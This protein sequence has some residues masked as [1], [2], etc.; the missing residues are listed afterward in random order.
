MCAI[1]IT[2][3]PKY[4]KMLKNGKLRV[5]ASDT[6]N[7]YFFAGVSEVSS[8]EIRLQVKRGTT[9]YNYALSRYGGLEIIP[10]QMGNGKYIATLCERVTGN[11]YRKIGRVVFNVK[12]EDKL[13]PFRH[14]NLWIPYYPEIARNVVGQKVED[15]IRY[16]YAYDYVRAIRIKAGALP[17]ILTCYEK[18]MGICQDLA[19]M[20]VSLWRMFGIPAKLVIGTV[21]KSKKL[22]AWCVTWDE[23]GRENVFDPTAEILKWNQ[24]GTYKEQR[25][26]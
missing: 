20:A 16:C 15:Y 24:T 26:Y 8:R 3:T 22:H 7:G 11:K 1:D 9:I 2:P 17:D 18:K 12:L 13:A 23:K 21:G 14:P 4:T 19:A 10:L 6:T 5:D 25:C